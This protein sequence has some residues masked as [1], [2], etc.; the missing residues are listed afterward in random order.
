MEACHHAPWKLVDESQP[1]D[2]Q[3]RCLAC[4][5]NFHNF[6]WNLAIVS[7]H[8]RRPCQFQTTLPIVLF[9]NTR[10]SVPLPVRRN[11][12][13]GLPRHTELKCMAIPALL[14]GPAVLPAS[15]PPPPQKPNT[16][17]VCHHA[18]FTSSTPT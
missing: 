18:A 3:A 6:S 15:R 5:I 2:L 7:F 16:G 17:P 4:H 1:L 14:L 11:E 10:I 13:I 9:P 8:H 12:A